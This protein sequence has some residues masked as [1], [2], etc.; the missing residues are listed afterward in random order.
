[1][2]Y[3]ESTIFRRS[4]PDFPRNT[5]AIS[6]STTSITGARPA[7]RMIFRWYTDSAIATTVASQAKESHLPTGATI[8]SACPIFSRASENVAYVPSGISKVCQ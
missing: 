5:A 1:M 2:R 7:G 8:C 3:N 6:S 4:P